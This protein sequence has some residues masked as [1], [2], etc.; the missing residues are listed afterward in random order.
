MNTS[1]L[2]VM[3]LV[4]QLLILAGQWTGSNAGAGTPALAQIPDPGNQR[5][6][7]IEELKSLNGKMDKIV[8]ILSDG[9]LQVRVAT[10]DESKREGHAR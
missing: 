5:I 10:P 3:V 9:D 6:Q 8:S 1:K 7:M 4:L 2:L